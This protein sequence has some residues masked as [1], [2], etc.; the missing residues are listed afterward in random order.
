M[1]KTVICCLFEEGANLFTL[2][3]WHYLDPGS[4]TGS[5][6]KRTG[7]DQISR[8]FHCGR[9]EKGQKSTGEQEG[10]RRSRVLIRGQSVGWAVW[11]EFGRVTSLP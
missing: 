10:V 6:A 7:K 2:C 5:S 1:L 11:G 8:N 9:G 3:A 4:R